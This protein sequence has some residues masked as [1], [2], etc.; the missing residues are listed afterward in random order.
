MTK[1]KNAKE[2]FGKRIEKNV[3]SLWKNLSRTYH[4][5]QDRQK[6]G[7]TKL[8]KNLK[9]SIKPELRVSVLL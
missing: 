1:T 4:Q 2:T 3:N 5:F 7:S 9:Q 6:N 8:T